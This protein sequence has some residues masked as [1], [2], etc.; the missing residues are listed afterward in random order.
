[1]YAVFRPAPNPKGGQR[2]GRGQ[3]S[4]MYSLYPS[5]SRYLLI[6]SGYWL[7]LRL[8]IPDNH[9]PTTDNQKPKVVIAAGLTSSHPE[10]RS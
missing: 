5:T 6:A 4:K 9:Q 7:G 8:R 2:A 3:L 10:Q 1:M